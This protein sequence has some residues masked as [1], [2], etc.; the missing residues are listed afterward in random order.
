MTRDFEILGSALQGPGGREA[1]HT[2]FIDVMTEYVR[3]PSLVEIL[4]IVAYIM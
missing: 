2:K 1:T 3:L 4:F